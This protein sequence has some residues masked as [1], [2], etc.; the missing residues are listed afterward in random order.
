MVIKNQKIKIDI[1][2]KKGIC[3][4]I[5]KMN[6]KQILLYLSLFEI[7]NKSFLEKLKNDIKNIIP[8]TFRLINDYK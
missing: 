1:N 8:K 7:D 3:I 5:N 2:Y 6:Y 4:R